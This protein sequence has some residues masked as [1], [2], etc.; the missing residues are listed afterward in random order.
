MEN[1]FQPLPTY[2]HSMFMALR[3]NA[4]P[5]CCFQN[6]WEVGSELPDYFALGS[7]VEGW[8][9]LEWEDT[10][11]LVEHAWACLPDMR[12]IDPSIIFLVEPETPLAYF[13]GVLY[14]RQ[15]TLAFRG[16]MLPRVVHTHGVDGMRHPG[17]KAAYDQAWRLAQSLA[18][19]VRPS[20]RVIVQ[21]AIV[22]SGASKGK[23]SSFE[24]E[25][26]ANA[27]S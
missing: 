17:Y 19:Q 23:S 3:T 13:P 5:N 26:D 16:E 14:R 1:T 24:E 6:A 10:V 2:R 8:L 11:V 7:Y 12:I 27:H 25:L 15:A 9:V 4:R 21:R 18:S 22:L 20:R